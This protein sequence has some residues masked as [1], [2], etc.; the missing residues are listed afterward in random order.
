MLQY[1]Q[2]HIHVLHKSEWLSAC[3]L[4][5]KDATESFSR[6]QQV[7]SYLSQL[8]VEA[9]ERLLPFSQESVPVPNTFVILIAFRIDNFFSC[10][11]FE[12]VSVQLLL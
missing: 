4:L 5:K 1:S 2:L 7:L 12:Y 9:D 6:S 11:G 8:S 3:W 10:C